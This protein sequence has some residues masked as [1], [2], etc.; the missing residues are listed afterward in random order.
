MGITNFLKR[1][2]TAGGWERLK[3]KTVSNTKNYTVIGSEIKTKTEKKVSEAYSEKESFGFKRKYSKNISMKSLYEEKISKFY[4]KEPDL[5]L[6]IES[7]RLY[8]QQFN[9]AWGASLYSLL[10]YHFK[11]RYKSK[12]GILLLYADGRCI[13]TSEN[14]TL[15]EFS[16]KVKEYIFEKLDNFTSL[17]EKEKTEHLLKH[18]GIKK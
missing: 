12:S 5:N 9:T 14:M 17:S 10:F 6:D 15:V 2:F 1:L 16:Q 18:L 3:A 7:V 13:M 11:I 4:Y 8:L